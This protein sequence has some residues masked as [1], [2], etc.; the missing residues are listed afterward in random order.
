MSPTISQLDVPELR[1]TAPHDSQPNRN[2]EYVLYWMTAFRRVESNYALQR[3]VYWAQLL[4][5]PLVILEPLR[6]GYR[7]ASD[8][9]H[10]FIVDGM[11]DNAAGCQSTN[12]FYYPYLEKKRGDGS[13]LIE[14]MAKRACVV[15]GDEYPC[16]FLRHLPRWFASRTP[17]RYEIVDSNGLMPLRLGDKLFTVAHSYRRFMQKQV[18]EL[19]TQRPIHQP[20]LAAKLKPVTTSFKD[21]QK[22][23]PMANEVLKS[24]AYEW[25][26]FDIDHTVPATKMVGGRTE[27]LKRWNEFLTK[28]RSKYNEDRNHPDSDGS[29]HLSPYLHFGHISPHEMFFSL[30]EH[31]GFKVNQLSKPNG[32]VNG[33]WNVSESAEA[34]LDQLLTWREIGFNQCFL[35]RVYDQYESLPA[36]ARA[37]LNKHTKDKR[38]YLYSLAQF[39]NAQTH[40]ELWNSAQR[41]LVR[42][43]R[44]HNYLRMLWGKKILHWSESPEEALRIMLELNNKYA[45]DGRDPNSYSGIFWVLGRYDRP[46]G[47]E[48]EIFGNIRY[49]TSDSTL[50]KVRTKNYLQKYSSSK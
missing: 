17:C 24:G 50:K 49:M 26:A 45:L 46:W 19:L 31:E 6:V 22:R 15:V 16:F 38:Q 41:Q 47:P 18:A 1:V 27:A 39:E 36:W 5:K 9:L 20:L 2:G 30:L 37:T 11:R 12:A 43:G 4:D 29:S 7:W 3:A 32:K 28:R 48:R 10:Q 8:R 35:D 40:D 33:F 34:F 23:W 42:D 44:I 25:S 21:I 13:G 14:A